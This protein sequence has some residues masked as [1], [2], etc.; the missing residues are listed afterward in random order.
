MCIRDRIWMRHLQLQ[1]RARREPSD[2]VRGQL[3]ERRVSLVIVIATVLWPLAWRRPFETAWRRVWR[4]RGCRG[5]HLGAGDRWEQRETGDEAKP[6]GRSLAKCARICSLDVT[7]R[8]F[9][10]SVA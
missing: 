8:N 9:A 10:P 4:D 5:R 6:H 3:T 7:S 1:Q 2:V